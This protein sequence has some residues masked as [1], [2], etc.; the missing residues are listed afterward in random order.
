MTTRFNKKKIS[1]IPSNKI[2]RNFLIIIFL[3]LFFIFI[4]RETYNYSHLNQLIENISKKINYQLNN[5]ELSNLKRVNKN[6]IL[7]ILSSYH[8]RSIFLLPLN[9]IAESIHDISWVK[10]VNLTTNL[11][12]T[13]SVDII[14][15]QPIGL[16]YYNNDFFYFSKEGKI[17]DKYIQANNEE[18]I[19]FYGKQVLNKANDFLGILENFGKE[20]LPKIQE[21][22]YINE[23]RWNIKLNNKIIIK[24]SEKNIADSIKNYNKLI[25]KLDSFEI[26]NI[27]YIDLR[28]NQKAIISFNND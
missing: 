15:H 13:I 2:L 4:F 10:K 18:F 28:D 25:S 6:D 9:E 17:I 12:N 22:F 11:K 8:N 3:F 19:I 7:N 23:R 20:D 26:N 1:I 21:A 14:E 5:Y 27:K 24:L 16:Y